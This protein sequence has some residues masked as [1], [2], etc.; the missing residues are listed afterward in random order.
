MKTKGLHHIAVITLG[1]SKNLVDSE[2]LAARLGKRGLEVDYEYQQGT[3]EAVIINTCGFI[4][5]AREESVETILQYLALKQQQKLRQVFVMGCLTERYREEVLQELPEIDGVYGVHEQDKILGDITG[6]LQKELTGERL[7]TTPSHYAYLK[8]AE[9][10]NRTCSFCA[11]PRIRGRNNS[12]P[13]EALKKEAEQLAAQGVKELILIAQDLTYY[14]IDNYGKRM[15]APL[16]LELET[17]AGIRWIRL[18]YTFPAQFPEEVLKVMQDSDK[19][20]NYLDIPLQH[21]NSE[22]LQSMCRGIDGTKTRELIQKIRREVPGVAL[23]TT[24]IA[25]YPGETETQFE[26][27]AAFV[28]EMQ[29]ERLGVFAYSHEEDTPASSLEDD[30]APEVKQQRAERIMALQETISLQ[31][32]TAKVGKEFTVVIDREDPEYYA[33]RTEFDSPEVDNEI[34]IRKTVPLKPGDFVNV[35]VE[36]AQPFDLY[37]SVKE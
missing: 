28:E 34:L 4:H 17:V 2:F 22:I 1:C 7:L 29:F 14:G 21:I 9:G 32:N 8:I 5:D 25:G 12:R 20:C 18:H 11:I 26:E 16:L 23:R 33:G 37:G 3:T 15:L 27:L 6:R 10:C 35:V 30:V 31:H 24:L 13:I 19:V 36:D